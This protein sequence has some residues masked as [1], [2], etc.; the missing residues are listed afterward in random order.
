MKTFKSTANNNTFIK[1]LLD[2]INSNTMRSIINK[3]SGNYRSQSFD[4][5]SHFF[6]NDVSSIE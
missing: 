5:Y 3:Y 1:Q 2:V 4:T 6:Y